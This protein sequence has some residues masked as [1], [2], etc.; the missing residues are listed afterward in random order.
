MWMSSRNGWAGQKGAWLCWLPKSSWRPW[1]LS[2]RPETSV[3]EKS[4]KVCD[5]LWDPPLYPSGKVEKSCKKDKG[6]LCRKWGFSRDPLGAASTLPESWGTSR[7]SSPSAAGGFC[8]FR[9]WFTDMRAGGLR[10]VIKPRKKQQ[11]LKCR[12]DPPL[13]QILIKWLELDQVN[14]VKE[15]TES[16][17][18]DQIQPSTNPCDYMQAEF[19]PVCFPY[20]LSSRFSS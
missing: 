15:T 7:T 6:P 20:W 11:F 10:E 19:S 8:P 17:K 4:I 18:S 13:M 3:H 14:H 1:S 12:E 2:S 5:A 16:D 9:N